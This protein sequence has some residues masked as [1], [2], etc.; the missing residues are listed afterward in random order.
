MTDEIE[1]FE[2]GEIYCLDSDKEYLQLACC[3]CGLVHRITL[4]PICDKKRGN[5]VLF[6][7]ERDEEA[8][9]TARKQLEKQP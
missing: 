7:L 4:N 8:T 2:D 5:L 1:Y 6:K 3:D 9:K